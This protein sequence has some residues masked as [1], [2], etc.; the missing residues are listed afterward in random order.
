MIPKY[1]EIYYDFLEVLSDGKVHTLKEIREKIAGKWK[2]SEEERISRIPSGT[3]YVFDSR[4][5]WARTYLKKAGF[6]E[7]PSRAIFIISPRGRNALKENPHGFGNS[8]LEQFSEFRE[9]FKPETE[10]LNPSK[11]TAVSNNE[12]ESPEEKMDQAYGLIFEGLVEEVLTEVTKM[13]PDAFEYLVV[14][15]LLSMG[16]G[17]SLS[18]NG[19][20]TEKS[21][22][23]GI[24]GI[25]KEDKLAFDQIYT[26][27]K[28]WAK[29]GSGS[30][31]EIQ[32]FVRALLGQGASKGL[33]ITTAKFSKQAIEYATKQ[34]STKIVLI[35]GDKLARLMI[36]NNLGVSVT[37]TY[38]IRRLDSDFFNEP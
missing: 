24:D 1:D 16:Y 21:G 29:D 10:S 33:Y 36:E 11:P 3:Q 20:V 26:Q 25:I 17:G 27:V 22:D 2:L 14:N 28:K 23:E 34:L 12:G 4:V 37:N 31:P 35:D 19:L 38:V 18:E 7:S 13:T 32:K 15:L 8:Y 9:F 6:I 5:G 30:R